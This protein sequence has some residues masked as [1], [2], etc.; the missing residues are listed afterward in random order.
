L[1]TAGVALLAPEAR[2]RQRT[3]PAS[4][5]GP[6]D[7]DLSKVLVPFARTEVPRPVRVQPDEPEE[8]FL[9]ITAERDRMVG[10][11]S[12]IFVHVE[13]RDAAPVDVRL[14]N[15]SLDHFGLAWRR[16]ENHPHTGGDG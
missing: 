5:A 12:Q 14:G 11:D 9:E 2:T 1:A 7:A 13:G 8:M 16:G 4:C 3:V 6:T 15:E 10:V